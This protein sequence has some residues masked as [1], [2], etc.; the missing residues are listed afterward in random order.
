MRRHS[1]RGTDEEMTLV[2]RPYDRNSTFNQSDPIPAI[3]ETD[4][5][6]Q[7]TQSVSSTGLLQHHAPLLHSYNSNTNSVS[8]PHEPHLH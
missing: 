4:E 3:S 6:Q 8:D 2:Y 5:D 7:I 1:K